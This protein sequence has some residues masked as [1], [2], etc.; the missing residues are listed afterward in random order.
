MLENRNYNSN[1]DTKS[2]ASANVGK[3]IANVSENALDVQIIELIRQDSKI[4]TKKMAKI[5]NVNPRTIQ[6]HIQAIEKIKRI[7]SKN[8]G[9]WEITE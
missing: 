9:H 8:G 4:S 7:G 6:R 2:A 1:A 3:N 5:L